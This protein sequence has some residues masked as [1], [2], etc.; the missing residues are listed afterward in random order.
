MSKEDKNTFNFLCAIFL[1]YELI[2]PCMRKNP[3]NWTHSYWEHKDRNKGTVRVA[4]K[5]LCADGCLPFASDW[6][7]LMRVIYKIQSLPLD[8]NTHNVWNLQFRTPREEV[9][10]TIYSFL[11][12]YYGNN[13]TI[14][15]Q[16]D[17]LE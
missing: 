12:S 17:N 6:N 7:A 15:C 11:N 4:D 13:K 9:M 16:L 14:L 2:S 8:T 1:D 3:S 10:Q 5:V